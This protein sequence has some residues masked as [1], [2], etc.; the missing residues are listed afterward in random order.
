MLS[1]GLWDALALWPTVAWPI[2]FSSSYWAFLRICLASRALQGVSPLDRGSAAFLPTWGFLVAGAAFEV[3]VHASLL[4][5]IGV[6]YLLVCLPIFIFGWTL[7]PGLLNEFGPAL[8]LLPLAHLFFAAA[9]LVLLGFAD[10]G[11]VRATNA[12]L[13]TLLTGIPVSL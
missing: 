8:V 7:L 9:F 5:L 11:F 12:Q 13:Y 1:R 3:A 6:P 10:I 4:W 2:A